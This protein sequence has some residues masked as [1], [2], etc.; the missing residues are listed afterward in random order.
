MQRNKNIPCSKL[1]LA[2]REEIFATAPRVD[3]WFLLEY[4]GAWTDKAFLD[5]KIPED[6]KERINLNLETIPNS[7]LQLIKRH[8]NSGHTL[9]FYVAKSD[10]LEPKLYEIDLSKYE[11]LLELDLNRILANDLYLRKEPLFLVCTNGSYDKCCGK[12]GV[13]VYLEAAKNETCFLI[14]QTTHLGGHRFAANVLCLPHGI[15]YGRVRESNV[16]SLLNEYQ[17]QLIN[18]ENYRGCSSYSKDVQA[19]EYFLRKMTGKAE[20]LAYQFREADNKDKENSIFEFISISGSKHHLVHIQK[21]KSA[22]MNYTSCGDDEKSPVTQ[23][24][25]I[26]YKEL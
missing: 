24:G 4:R 7:R 11:D 23:Y 22:F 15:Y 16:Q 1:S 9:K 14:W 20:I 13:S 25:L 8:D 6:V 12:Y 10:E 17:K 18:L 5:S 21:D 19:A 3:V 26:E 2:A